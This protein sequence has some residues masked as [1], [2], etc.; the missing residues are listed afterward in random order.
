MAAQ[1]HGRVVS[2]NIHSSLQITKK[3]GLRSSIALFSTV[4]DATSHRHIKLT[5]NGRLADSL[6]FYNPQSR[7]TSHLGEEAISPAVMLIC[8]CIGFNFCRCMICCPASPFEWSEQSKLCNKSRSRWCAA[9]HR[10][11]VISL[12]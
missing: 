9:L 4:T 8:A 10:L 7:L 12:Q 1:L 3:I 6:Q 11:L 5:E 2:F